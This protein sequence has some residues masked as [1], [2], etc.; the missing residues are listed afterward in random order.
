[1]NRNRVRRT[2]LTS[3]PLDENEAQKRLDDVRS[4]IGAFKDGTTT[5]R[6]VLAEKRANSQQP[7]ERNEGEAKKK[8]TKVRFGGG[9]SMVAVEYAEDIDDYLR[10]LQLRYR[11]PEDYLREHRGGVDGRMR[12][13]LVDW[14]IHV[15]RRFS[16]FTETMCVTVNL[17]DR[18]L[19]AMPNINKDNLQLLGLACLF[20]A[21]KFEE[22]L[23]PNIDDYIHV[24]ANVFSKEDI[25]Q[26][27]HEILNAVNFDMCSVHSIQ[28]LRRYR[29]YVNPESKVYLLAKYICDVALVSYDLVHH[30][31]STVAA[32]AMW[33]ASYTHG[34]QLKKPS[35]FAEVFKLQAQE[36]Q[37]IASSFVEQ[38]IKFAEPTERLHAVRQKH[39]DSALDGLT[40]K[41]F[42]RLQELADFGGDELPLP[43]VKK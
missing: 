38:V 10:H 19:M 6:G 9:S 25:F 24:A 14:L 11:V 28:F 31:P 30:S 36:L 35:L 29:F 39:Q 33:L 27:E 2:T 16:F 3:A 37:S 40:E 21:S 18:S 15:Q 8:Q 42:T 43:A 32:V 12:Q 1:M 22:V 20:T 17:L 7:Q 5:S 13:I 34:V 23:V 4:A 26:M 41:H